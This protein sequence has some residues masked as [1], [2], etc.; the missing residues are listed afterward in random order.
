MP[1]TI[2]QELV[3][4]CQSQKSTGKLRKIEK[5]FNKAGDINKTNSKFIPKNFNAVV[6]LDLDNPLCLEI[7]SNLKPLEE[8]L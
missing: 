4:H 7:Y 3:I 8:L 5:L 1:L 2:G 6:I